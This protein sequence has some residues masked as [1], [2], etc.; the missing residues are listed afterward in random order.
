MNKYTQ[1]RLRSQVCRLRNCR[2]Q[3]VEDQDLCFTKLL[4]KEQVEAAMQRHQVRFRKRLYTQLL[5]IWTC[6]RSRIVVSVAEM[7]RFLV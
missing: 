1:G 7:G 4:P 5:T 3:M 6:N 2:K